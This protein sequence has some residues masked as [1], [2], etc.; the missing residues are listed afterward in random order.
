MMNDIDLSAI[1]LKPI[2]VTFFE[3]HDKPAEPFNE[4][5]EAQYHLLQKPI[6]VETYRY[7]YSEVGMKHFWLDRIVMNDDQ[8]FQLINADNTDIFTMKIND[9]RAGYAEFIKDK[10]FIEILYFGLMPAFIG[11]GW[12]K[13]SLDW[14]IQKAWSYNP[15]WIQLNTCELD[16]P[17]AISNYKKRGFTEVK[18]EILE[19]KVLP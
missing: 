8:L 2:K 5:C 11:K 18:T 14:A 10:K 17:H 12:G 19:R 6:D 13:Y 7:Y 4:K 16:H 9:Q 3:I 15:E 1:T